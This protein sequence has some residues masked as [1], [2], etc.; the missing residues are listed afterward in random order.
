MVPYLAIS[1]TW[2]EAEPPLTVF[3]N[4]ESRKVRRNCHYALWQARLHYADS[5][6][7][8]D[9]VCID[10]ESLS[11]K[12]QQVAIM[13]AIYGQAVKVLACIGPEADDSDYMLGFSDRFTNEDLDA[14]GNNT[15]TSE[16][17]LPK[18][19]MQGLEATKSPAE[20]QR[21]LNGSQNFIGRTYWSRVWILQ[22]LMMARSR[23]IL[24]GEHDVPFALMSNMDILANTD[25]IECFNPRFQQAVHG[26]A[27]TIIEGLLST[28]HDR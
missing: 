3:V 25:G 2:G 19:L 10:Q 16:A 5:F 15:I 20:F 17:P 23:R 1:Y 21:F 18:A 7:W 24:C 27:F 6:I 12:S 11:E 22:E 8:I 9:S 26:S 4:G 13:G 14:S 28:A